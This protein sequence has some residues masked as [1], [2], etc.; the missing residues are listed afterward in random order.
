MLF[1]GIRVLVPLGVTNRTSVTSSLADNGATLV[2]ALPADCVIAPVDSTNP[3]A[4][5]PQWITDCISR[6]LLLSTSDYKISRSSS[7]K[8]QPS[9]SKSTPSTTTSS[10]ARRHN[11][12]FTPEEDAILL[13]HY[14]ISQCK[15]SV[16]K[17]WRLLSDSPATSRTAA[18]LRNRWK[19]LSQADKN[20][21]YK[22]IFSRDRVWAR[23]ALEKFVEKTGAGRDGIQTWIVFS[24]KMPCFSAQEWMDL[25]VSLRLDSQNNGDA[26]ARHSPRKDQDGRAGDVM[27]NSRRFDSKQ[28]AETT[29][30]HPFAYGESLANM[31]DDHQ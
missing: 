10:S 17:T 13:K 7:F 24:Q 23:I 22:R 1:E 20:V 5:Q 26:G 9:R 6:N 29:D 8:Q 12:S 25:Y 15:D 18:S 27:E 31:D 28:F 21:Y 19:K 4:V 16:S 2:D 11:S 3:D 30:G 14:V